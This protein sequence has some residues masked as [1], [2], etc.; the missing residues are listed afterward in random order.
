MSFC[1]RT[2]QQQARSKVNGF[3]HFT[4]SLVALQS[5]HALFK[6]HNIGKWLAFLIPYLH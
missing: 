1:G 2:R 5:F 4:S 6:A 3:Y